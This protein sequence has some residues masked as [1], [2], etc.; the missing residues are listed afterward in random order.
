MAGRY[1]EALLC[2]EEEL[3]CYEEELLIHTNIFSDLYR[4]RLSPRLT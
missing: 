4:S 1:G 3:L 2:Y